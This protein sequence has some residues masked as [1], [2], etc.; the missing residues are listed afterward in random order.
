[1]KKIGRGIQTYYG[2]SLYYVTARECVV[3]FPHVWPPFLYRFSV[4]RDDL[5][6]PSYPQFSFCDLP[7]LIQVI[8]FQR[9][10]TTRVTWPWWISLGLQE[11]V[12]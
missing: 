7:F 5:L 4:D 2:Y 12:Q 8:N 9:F 1:M 3:F 6:S 11:L 10:L